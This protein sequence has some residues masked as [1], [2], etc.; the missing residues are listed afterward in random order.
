MVRAGIYSNAATVV[1][2]LHG[3]GKMHRTARG[4][5]DMFTSAGGKHGPRALCPTHRWRTTTE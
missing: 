4:S 5:G 1:T 3:I 2:A